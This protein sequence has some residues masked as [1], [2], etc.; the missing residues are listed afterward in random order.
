MT[1]NYT[2]GTCQTDL[3]GNGSVD[4]WCGEGDLSNYCSSQYSVDCP[5]GIKRIPCG[6]SDF[7]L[8]FFDNLHFFVAMMI[9]SLVY[10][11]GFLRN[12]KE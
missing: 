5:G 2:P 4:D 10:L 8:G 3:N 9:I 6:G 12:R 11:V 7:E 1:V